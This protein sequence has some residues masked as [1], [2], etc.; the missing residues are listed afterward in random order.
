[1]L[2]AFGSQQFTET[3]PLQTFV[4]PLSVQQV[5]S[6]LKLP[7]RVIPDPDEAAMLTAF[8]SAAREQAEIM[9]GR[10]LVRKQYDLSFD[11]WP[12]QRLEMGAPLVSVDLVQYKSYDGTVTTLAENLDYFVD[13]G[14]TPGLITPPYN[15]PWPMFTPWPSSALLIRYTCGFAPADPFWSDAGQRI[16]VGMLMLISAWY[17][18]RLPFV[19]GIGASSEYPYAVTS[20]LQMGARLRGA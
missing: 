5:Q 4:E 20:C 10:D 16:K 12:V 8:I 7:Q 15:T 3:S 6:F 11:Y 14:K 9:Q 2:V 17:N 18:N 1:M 13:L 19:R